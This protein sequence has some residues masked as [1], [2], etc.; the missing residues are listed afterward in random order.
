MLKPMSQLHT[1][2]AFKESIETARGGEPFD[3]PVQL[4]PRQPIHQSPLSHLQPVKETNLIGVSDTPLPVKPHCVFQ[5]GSSSASSPSSS[6]TWRVASPD[7]LKQRTKKIRMEERGLNNAILSAQNKLQSMDQKIQSMYQGIA[8]TNR[9]RE[10]AKDR[11]QREHDSLMHD[12][13]V[14]EK[15]AELRYASIN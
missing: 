5:S 12:F 4:Y 2:V 13:A 6:P 8:A 11:D 10:A 1:S 3:D 14:R 9:A 7:E 15:D